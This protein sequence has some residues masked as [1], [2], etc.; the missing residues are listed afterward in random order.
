MWHNVPWNRIMPSKTFENSLRCINSGFE[1]QKLVY[2]EKQ[3]NEFT[4]V[5]GFLVWPKFLS[6][7][8]LG[9]NI[10]LDFKKI[11]MCI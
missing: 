3:G 9:L 8:F 11:Y 6:I 2:R 1:L 10:S 4:Y 7:I 5:Y